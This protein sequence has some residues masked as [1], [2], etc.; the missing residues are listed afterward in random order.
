MDKS[1]NASDGLRRQRVSASKAAASFA[2]Q[3]DSDESSDIEMK[4][5]VTLKDK[6]LASMRKER[7]EVKAQYGKNKSRARASSINGPPTTYHG[8]DAAMSTMSQLVSTDKKR[9]LYLATDPLLVTESDASDLTSLSSSTTTS[10]IDN[11]VSRPPLCTPPKVAPLA[12]RRE[13][14]YGRLV[15]LNE[16]AWSIDNLGSYVWVLL[17]PKSNR[18]YNPD[19]DEIDCIDRLWW[20]AK[21]SVLQ[22]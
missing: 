8:S 6:L 14:E 20:P 19:R 21:V 18:V 15:E 17:E 22:V 7:V 5:D 9:S 4:E 1:T 11:L 16:P 10:P 3:L 13:V 2:H 12:A